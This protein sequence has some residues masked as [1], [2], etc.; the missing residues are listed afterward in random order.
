[1][2]T[3]TKSDPKFREL[4][5]NR[6]KTYTLRFNFHEGQARVWASL[7]RF[8][9]FLAGSQVGKTVFGPV[10]MEREIREKGP[11]DY[12]AGTATFPLMNL[13]MLPEYQ[14]H[15][16]DTMHYG[17]LNQSTKVFTFYREADCKGHPERACMFTDAEYEADGATKTRI[18][19]FSGT[20]ANSIES[21]TAK[22]A[23][24]DEG[25]QKDFR[26]DSWEA[27]NRRLA[28][29]SGRG[30]GRILITTTPYCLGWLK[31]ELVDPWEQAK[32]NHPDID[33]IQCE[34]IANPL[35]PKAEFERLRATLP[36]WKF[37]MFCRG[38]FSRPTG[39]IYDCFDSVVHVKDYPPID[40]KW[41][42][43]TGH[44]FG[45]ANTAAIWIAR[46]PALAHYYIIKE[47][48]RGGLATHEHVDAWQQMS[49]DL[50]V[51]KSSGGNQDEDGARGD[52]SRAGW[53]IDKPVAKRSV[54]DGIMRV[55]SLIKAGRLFVC[56]NC[57]GVLDE[58]QSY[59]YELD[60]QYKPTEKI[61]GK[62][63]YHYMDC[64]RYVTS[65]FQTPSAIPTGNYAPISTLHF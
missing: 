32:G 2:A 43:Y 64:L 41:L 33:V 13:K 19:F 7:K 52:F 46:D 21:A 36:D 57:P 55:Y 17:E 31:T 34:S 16:Q 29:A 35:Y 4:V 15:F 44:D 24:I 65:D 54:D 56:R 18:I 1:M 45:T 40:N 12:L 9:I 51:I 60:E 23:H 37:Q 25:G 48:K 30:A 58:L 6:D 38:R 11:G 26:H 49:T 42:V 59:S 50:K 61:E 10:W 5:K 28:L 8:V 63:K 3:A 62:A 47:Y 14:L 27:I 53:R 39:L 22:A 20:N